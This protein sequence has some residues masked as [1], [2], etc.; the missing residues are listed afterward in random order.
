MRT[1]IELNTRPARERDEFR[2]PPLWLRRALFVSLLVDVYAL[3]R[4]VN[5]LPVV[6]SLTAIYGLTM[7]VPP[8][9]S[10]LGMIRTP[11]V[12]FLVTLMLLWSP[13]HVLVVISFGTLLAVLIFRLYEFWRAAINTVWWAFPAALAS[14][15]GHAVLHSTRGQLL[16]LTAASLAIL[17]V[18]LLT[19]FALL[20]LYRHLRHGEPFLAYWW[21]CLT[22]NPLSQVLAAP[23]P[24]LLGAVAI[25]LGQGQ[26]T[27]LVLTALSAVTM[28]TVRLQLAV[29]LAS[30]RT[31]RDIVRALMIALERVVPGARAHSE[32]VSVLVNEM[33]LRLHVSAT[34]LESWRTAALLH[35]IGLIDAGSR[36]VSPVS[37]AI[38]GAR[39]LDSYPDQMVADMVRE[40][41]TPWSA[42]PPRLRSPVVLG[43]RVLAAA[44][45]YDELR[46]GSPAAPG[47]MTHRATV[48]AL[49]PMIG[50]Q[51]S[52]RIAAVLFEAA[53]RLE[54][55]AA[56]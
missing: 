41:H 45:C 6:A 42:V 34:T 14:F 26:W 36:G 51:L 25:G 30:Q 15:I 4:V 37:H 7:L 24:I 47:L 28:P 43:A 39:I 12:A 32:R 35:D 49:Q 11:R 54:Q 16:G 2:D 1:I 40:H 13:L 19:N 52:P 23:V 46:Y 5:D 38:V 8:V 48:Q 53:E 18:Y 55:K 21:S 29:F 33:G 9:A 27:N 17:V 50:R 44:E 56:S 22:E 20:A 10:P 31:V 3:T